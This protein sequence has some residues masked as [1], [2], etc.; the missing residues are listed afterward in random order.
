MNSETVFILKAILT[1]SQSDIC[2][3]QLMIQALIEELQYKHT[4]KLKNI[5]ML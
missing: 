1:Q 3:A 2:K 4:P 5:M